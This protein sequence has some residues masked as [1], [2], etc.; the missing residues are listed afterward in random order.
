MKR[1]KLT[2]K[3]LD[4]HVR[5]L[6]LRHTELKPD[7]RFVA[8]FLRAYLTE[9]EDEAVGALCGASNDKGTDAVL[10]DDNARSVFVIQGKYHVG[11][12]AKSEARSAVQAFAQLARTLS[13]PNKE[14]F[15]DA[16]RGANPTAAKLLEKARQRI[17]DRSY[18]L[19]LYYVT[20]G[21]VSQVQQRDARTVANSAAIACSLEFFDG[22]RVL[23]V[24]RDYL[25][26]VA[27][28]VPML[29]F[30][31]ERAAGVHVNGVFQRYDKQHKI[32][33][34][35]FST[36]GSALGELYQRTGIRLFARNIRG[37]L[38]RDTPVNREMETT[39]K[40]APDFFFYYNNGVTVLCE[41]AERTSR[42][43]ADVL[44]VWN[45]QIINGQQ[46]TR[47]LAETKAKNDGSSVLVKV[48][49][50]PSLYRGPTLS[51]EDLLG[52]IVKGT[53]WQNKI[54]R[55]DLVANDPRQVQLERELRK[56]GYVYLRKGQAKGEV[57]RL[58]AVKARR[59]IK[60]EV[61]AQAVGSTMLDPVVVRKGIEKLFE[62]SHYETVFPSADPNFYLPRYALLRGVSEIS[63]QK[64]AWGYMKW[65]AMYFAWP[66]LAECVRGKREARAFVDLCDYPKSEVATALR[67]ALRCVFVQM[68]HFFNAN[69]RVDGRTLDV[70]QFFK[71]R[72]GLPDQFAGFWRRRGN[73]S[74][75]R[76]VEH[77]G[78]L[79]DA[80]QDYDT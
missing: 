5:E 73:G 12:M 52:Q 43:G 11:I 60:K 18:A 64:P 3:D 2:A 39:L 76:F 7:E 50:V 19:H 1:E 34:W 74:A 4:E 54:K 68:G 62:D 36:R 63:R 65:L 57:R 32:E 17:V 20:T 42:A 8:W 66:H 22:D 26:G 44:R 6:G 80:I 61:L 9:N 51:F 21:K 47:M 59:I 23:S 35:V 71:N 46:T 79:R 15:A 67:A 25:D 10:I 55:S 75:S 38:G 58:H 14:E 33:S 41:R 78:E 77:V 53:N 30:E 49:Q 37:F 27:P 28:P 40:T 16:L 48:I 24:L 72:Q 69:K 29:D 56:R 45:P 70:S 31:I 13:E